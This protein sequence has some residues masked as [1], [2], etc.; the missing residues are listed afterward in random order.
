VATADEVE[1][2]EEAV[3]V[4][5]LAC[6][7]DPPPPQPVSPAANNMQMKWRLV[8]FM[9]ALSGSYLP[10]TEPVVAIVSGRLK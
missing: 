9:M 3:E 5:A 1:E 10:L 8:N 4:L 7:P 6:E 2:D